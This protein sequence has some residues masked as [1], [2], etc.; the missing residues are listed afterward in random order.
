MICSVLLV[1][2]IITAQENN[3]SSPLTAVFSAIEE[4]FGYQFNYAKDA[5][6]S[7]EI[8]PPPNQFTFQETLNYL[9]KNTGFSYI[10]VNPHFVL[11]TKTNGDSVLKNTNL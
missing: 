1:S 9:K 10:V 8:I 2:S 5:V 6:E 3:K 7:V 4:R 11:V